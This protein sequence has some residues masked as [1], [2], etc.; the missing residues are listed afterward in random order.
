MIEMTGV[1]L[2]AG[3]YFVGDP[4]YGVPNDRWMEWLEAANYEDNPR[5][6]VAALNER[7]VVGVGTAYGDGEYFDQQ[8][9]RYPVDAGLIG[10]V[11]V[12]L[13]GNGSV[14]PSGMHRVTFTERFECRYDDGTIILGSIQID[15]DPAY[16]ND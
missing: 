12:E 8:G 14:T 7:T 2:P 3:D 15:T 5:L 16:E 1:M 13:V 11:P 10:V 9:R 6:L 4:C